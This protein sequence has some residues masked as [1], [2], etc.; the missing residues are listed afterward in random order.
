MTQTKPEVE[1]TTR[2]A[3]LSAGIDGLNQAV[4]ALYSYKG[5]A[6]YKD[7][8][9]GA[10]LHPVYMSQCLSASRDVGLTELAGKRGLYKLTARGDEYARH[11]SYGEDDKAREILSEILLENPS[12]IE[13]IKFLKMSYKQERNALSLVADVEA[14]L[15]KHWKQSARSVY[16]N[17][18]VSVL[19]FAGLI[20]VS[21]DNIISRVSPE[22]KVQPSLPSSVG[23][24]APRPTLSSSSAA[25]A[26]EEYCEFSIPDSFKIFVRKEIE[27]L[28][29]FESQVKDSSIFIPWIRHEKSKIAT[30]SKKEESPE[31]EKGQ[32]G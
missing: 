28:S 32:V 17:T 22:E 5:S 13:I 8:A 3:T 25:L 12:W 21:G 1:K 26:P 19:R 16:A 9:K 23:I 11:L 18:Y 27:S 15:G 14:K 30:I 6:T 31:A 4:R 24:H 7:L 2:I 29:F 20:D 10:G